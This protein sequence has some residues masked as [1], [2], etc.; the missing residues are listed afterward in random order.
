MTEDEPEQG[1]PVAFGEWKQTNG[2][3]QPP[4]VTGEVVEPKRPAKKRRGRPPGSKTKK[5]RVSAGGSSRASGRPKDEGAAAKEPPPI[6]KQ[7]PMF[8]TKSWRFEAWCRLFDPEGKESGITYQGEP[9]E[10]VQAEIKR[11]EDDL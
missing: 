7:S 4:H 8:G 2:T 9:S 6:P 10:H 1:A 3:E 11:Y 5:K